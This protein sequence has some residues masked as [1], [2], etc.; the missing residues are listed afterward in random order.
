MLAKTLAVTCV[1]KTVH[2]NLCLKASQL[3]ELLDYIRTSRK[4]AQ[5]KALP[6]TA[7]GLAVGAAS[8]NKLVNTGIK[9]SEKLTP[10]RI[11]QSVLAELLEAGPDV[12]IVQAF[13]GHQPTPATEQYR[14]H[15]LVELPDAVREMHPR[16]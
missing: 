8:L 5:P 12:R 4:D 10:L 1:G 16:G 11:W 9:A 14:R 7:T 15:L 3:L 13:A 6:I 2:R